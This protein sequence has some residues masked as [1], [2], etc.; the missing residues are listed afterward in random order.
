MCNHAS[1]ATQANS[2]VVVSSV[3]PPAAFAINDHLMCFYAG[4]DPQAVR[5]GEQ[6]NWYDDAAM[7]LG[8]ASYVVHRDDR[9]VVYDTFCSPVHARWIRDYLEGMGIRSF[10]VVLSHWHLD[11]VAG[12][13]VY[14]D[15][16]IVGCELTRA[17]LAEKRAEI[18]DGRLWGPPAIAPLVPPNVTFA[19]RMDLFVKDI[20][21]ELHN[22]N[23]HSAD[24]TVMYLPGNGVLLAGDALE[25]SLT[26][27]VEIENLPLHLQNLER[28]RALRAE[29][30]YPNHG[31]PDVLAAGGYST[32]L[33]DATANYITR[34]L[35]R[36]HDANYLSG[37]MEDYIGEE[38]AKGWVRPHEAYRDVHAQ[39][40]KLV[41]AHYAGRPLPLLQ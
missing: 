36:A 37:S 25:D 8:I 28:L 23:I 11:H 24:T 12:N 6:W 35:T 16:D 1:S 20:K 41:Q 29:R 27:M 39:N 17:T 19:R 22:V 5:A 40:L 9:A 34:M 18:E 30:I 26:Y 7:K 2:A 14:A 13:A 10:T 33:I 4:R 31:H 21:I 3:T 32:T 38:A 15:R